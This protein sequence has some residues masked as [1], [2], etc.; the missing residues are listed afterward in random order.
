MFTDPE[1]GFDRV[2]QDIE[3][4]KIAQRTVIRIE[5]ESRAIVG[6]ALGR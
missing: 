6:N 1:H 3:I 2:C 4:T 5:H